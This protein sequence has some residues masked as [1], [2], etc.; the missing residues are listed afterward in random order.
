M[1]VFGVVFARGGSKGLPGKNLRHVGG[2][3]LLSHAIAAGQKA[4]LVDKVLVSTDSHEI[5]LAAAPL[6]AEVPFLRPAEL[7]EDHSPEWGAW[8]HLAGYLMACGAADSDLLVSVPT[9]APLRLPKDIDQAVNTFQNG[10]FDVVLTVTESARSPW[11]NMVTRDYSGRV[12]L[13]LQGGNTD[14][15]RRQDAP[16]VF[17]IT[18]VAYV[19]SLGFVQQAKRLFDGSV[20]SVT[21][22]G[23]RAIDVDTELDLRIADFLMMER[24]GLGRE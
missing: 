10:N 21:V 11:F 23:E 22:P 15:H 4:D 1:T 6:G 16:Q 7:S 8:Q 24:V 20:G 13:T 12:Q 3:S 14:L 18:T 19:T 9:T 2:R 17:D 5:M